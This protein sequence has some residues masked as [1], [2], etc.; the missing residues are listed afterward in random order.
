VL[1]LVVA[2]RAV[3]VAA[4]LH[5]LGS[6]R[7]VVS[8]SAVPRSARGQK[9][10]PDRGFG[11]LP[12]RRRRF[13]VEDAMARPQ[14]VGATAAAMLP[15]ALAAAVLVSAPFAG[16]TTAPLAHV[17][18]A[19]TSVPHHQ[20]S[21]AKPSGTQQSAGGDSTDSGLTFSGPAGS[22]AA[23]AAGELALVGVGVGVIVAARRR[24]Y[25]ED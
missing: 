15:T 12:E 14:L 4:A 2:H 6:F 3:L 10:I 20:P 16:T 5:R 9:G 25:A 11:H 21:A 24:R 18:R 23:L 7:R 1:E 22:V 8:T 17:Q 13:G 19:G